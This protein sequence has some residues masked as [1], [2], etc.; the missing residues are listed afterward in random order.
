MCLRT[1]ES[2]LF[3]SSCSFLCAR[4]AFMN[5]SE[6]ILTPESVILNILLVGECTQHA[7]VLLDRQFHNVALNLEQ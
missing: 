5:E 1:C 4:R 2:A 6:Y 7:A 3:D